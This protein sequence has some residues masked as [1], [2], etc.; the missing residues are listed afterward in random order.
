MYDGS[1]WKQANEFLG[2]KQERPIKNNTRM[3]RQ[4][5]GS[6]AIYYHGTKIVE[7]YQDGC[8]ML[9]NGS[10]YTSTTKERLNYYSKAHIVQRRYRWFI[11][12]NTQNIEFVNGITIDENG[13]VIWPTE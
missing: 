1:S 2:N 7:Y 9:R 10:Y 11:N 5:D 4:T 13:S 8:T 6:I 12:P 3:Y